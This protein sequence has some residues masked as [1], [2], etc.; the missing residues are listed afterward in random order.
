MAGDTKR[1]LQSVNAN[2]RKYFVGAFKRYQKLNIYGKVSADLVA[3][4]PLLMPL[5]ALTGL[6]LAAYSLPHSS[7]VCP[8]SLWTRP[9]LPVPL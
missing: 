2:I 9:H 3:R 4:C 5:G 1:I 6:R 7:G 8:Y